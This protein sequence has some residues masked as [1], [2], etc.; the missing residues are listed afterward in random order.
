M[1]VG[2]FGKILLFLPFGAILG[3]PCLHAA[4]DLARNGRRFL[5]QMTK[6]EMPQAIIVGA[7]A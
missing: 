2:R 5:W 3:I 6:G 7:P 4:S 1:S